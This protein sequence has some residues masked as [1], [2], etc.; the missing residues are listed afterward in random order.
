MD[1][2]KNIVNKKK[3]TMIPTTFTAYNAYL[4]VHCTNVKCK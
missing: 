3:L 1:P 2:W 4:I